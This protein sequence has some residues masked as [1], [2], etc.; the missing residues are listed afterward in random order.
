[1]L[2]QV[3]LR[4]R[5]PLICSPATALKSCGE[6]ARASTASA[7]TTEAAHRTPFN[8][9]P[10]PHRA[11]THPPRPKPTPPRQAPCRPHARLPQR[12]KPPPAP[13]PAS[14]PPPT[15]TPAAPGHVQATWPLRPKTENPDLQP[16]SQIDFP[17]TCE[18]TFF[19]S[20]AHENDRQRH[21]L[22]R[23]AS[24]NP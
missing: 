13:R 15:T 17:A 5:R 14:P 6:T 12:R 4:S 22:L 1:P 23:C 9:I 8:D 18:V 7:S 21:L 10:L 2:T 20:P 16:K 24:A 3:G 11:P 19:V